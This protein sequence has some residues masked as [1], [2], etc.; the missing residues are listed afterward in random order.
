[1]ELLYFSA[2]VA[3]AASDE[4]PKV[5]TNVWK[6]REEFYKS[7]MP[8]DADEENNMLQRA[9]DE[10]QRQQQIRELWHID[11]SQL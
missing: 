1:M 7:A 6:E 2:A 11:V 5:T 9:L 4:S 3:A 8:K 10:S